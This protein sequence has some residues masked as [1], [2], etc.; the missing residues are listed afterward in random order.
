MI[1][2]DANLMLY[3][4]YESAQQHEAARTWW[5]RQLSGIA[6]VCLC[7]PVL[8]AFIR[9][10]TNHRI[11]RSPLRVD[12][13]IARVSSW[14]EQPCVRIITPTASHWQTLSTLLQS[15]QATANLVTDAHLAALAIEHG[16]ELCS[17]DA[18]FARFPGLKYRNPLA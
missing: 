7:W 14:L 18:D 11:F 13:A 12:E 3:A 9:I 15:G 6:P 8:T 2:V 5:D 17:A 4:E 10:A 1:L 16:C